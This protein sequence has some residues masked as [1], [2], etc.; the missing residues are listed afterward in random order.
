MAIRDCSGAV[1]V[2]E[3]KNTCP[4]QLR[5]VSLS[6]KGKP[7]RRYVLADPGPRERVGWL[8]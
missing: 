4:F 2:V 6:K 5:A 1:E 3:V 7:G 8:S